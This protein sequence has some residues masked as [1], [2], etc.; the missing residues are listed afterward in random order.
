MQE[1]ARDKMPGR[2]LSGGLKSWCGGW[3]HVKAEEEAGMLQK[4]PLG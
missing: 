2:S 3:E 1:R 4:G